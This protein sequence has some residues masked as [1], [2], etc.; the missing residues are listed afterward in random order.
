MKQRRKRYGGCFWFAAV[1]VIAL[2]LLTELRVDSNRGCV[3][4]V[5]KIRFV[6]FVRATGQVVIEDN[7]GCVSAG[8]LW[9]RD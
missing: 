9:G 2:L 5:W 6:D 1:A 8:V 7:G 3:S 4:V